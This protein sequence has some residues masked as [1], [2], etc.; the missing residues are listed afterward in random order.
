MRI[1]LE[2]WVAC[3]SNVHILKSIYHTL[4]LRRSLTP[5]AAVASAMTSFPE[6]AAAAWRALFFN[7]AT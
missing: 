2:I 4:K 5:D 6:L 1:I 3:I 7:I